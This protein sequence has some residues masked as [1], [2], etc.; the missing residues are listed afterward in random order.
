MQLTNAP[1]SSKTMEEVRGGVRK[2]H[3]ILQS[4]NITV[5][6]MPARGLAACFSPGAM[7]V[8]LPSVEEGLPS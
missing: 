3:T 2:K 8:F 7:G 5:L 4:L 1:F 6:S